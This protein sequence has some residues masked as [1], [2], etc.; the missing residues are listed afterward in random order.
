[1]INPKLYQNKKL[2]EIR[3]KMKVIEKDCEGSIFQP[4]DY[5]DYMELQREE[6]KE[7]AHMIQ[8]ESLYRIGL[9]KKHCTCYNG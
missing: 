9:W 2:W 4:D 1:M 3:D 7:V 5:L 8:K 6:W